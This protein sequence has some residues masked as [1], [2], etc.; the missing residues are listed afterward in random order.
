MGPV[1]LEM[2]AEDLG[3]TI[4]YWDEFFTVLRQK[5]L[6]Y[7]QKMVQEYLKCSD[8]ARYDVSSIFKG[9]NLV[10]LKQR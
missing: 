10:L 1:S 9:G 6:T 4:G 7:D 5:Q 2:A 3:A 8:L